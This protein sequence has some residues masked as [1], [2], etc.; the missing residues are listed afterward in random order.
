[1]VTLADSATLIGASRLILSIMILSGC[2]ARPAVQLPVFPRLR[3]WGRRSS[4]TFLIDRFVEVQPSDHGVNI[5][6]EKIE[7]SED[8][9]DRSHDDQDPIAVFL[10]L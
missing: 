2:P 4:E 9:Q 1:M 5:I 3:A 7:N 10:E 8:D 6:I